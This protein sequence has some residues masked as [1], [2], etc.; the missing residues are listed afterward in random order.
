MLFQMDNENDPTAYAKELKF[1]NLMLKRAKRELGRLDA[2][3]RNNHEYGRDVSGLQ[4]QFEQL[5]RS[6][7]VFEQELASYQLHYG[8]GTT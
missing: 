1:G 2:Q 3:I 7:E 4:V 5:Q 8:D 6:V